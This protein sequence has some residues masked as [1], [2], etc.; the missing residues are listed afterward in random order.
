MTKPNKG[1]FAAKHPPGTTVEPRIAQAVRA[2]LR[3]GAISCAAAHAIAEK[4]G[5]DPIQIGIAIDLQDGRILKCQMGLFGYPDGKKVQPLQ[6]VD[7]VLADAIKQAAPRGRL[8]CAAAWDIAE[9]RSLSKREA[10]DACESLNIRI[11]QC[12]LGAF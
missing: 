6:T 11:V 7:Q 1:H 10:A 12:Q 9:K 4:L 5:V 8:T 2:N 3:N